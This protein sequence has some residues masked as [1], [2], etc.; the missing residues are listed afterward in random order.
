MRTTGCSCAVLSGICFVLA[1]SAC[2]RAH[3]D[4]VFL[5]YGFNGYLATDD[6][7]MDQDNP[8]TNYGSELLLGVYGEVND[9][10]EIDESILIRFDLTGVLPPQVV[11]D[12]AR[13]GFRLE[14]KRRLTG[15]D[16]EVS[17]GA[18]R[19]LN[20]PWIEDEATWYVFNQSAYWSEPGCEWEGLDRS[21]IEDDIVDFYPNSVVGVMHYWDVTDSVIEWCEEGQPNNGW[22]LRVETCEDQKR[23]VWLNS[24]EDPIA[25]KRPVL[26]VWYTPYY[27]LTLNVINGPWGTV[28]VDPDEPNYEAGTPVVLTAEPNP[29]KGFKHWEIYDPNHPGDPNYRVTDGN[30]VI[31]IVMNADREVTAVFKCGAGTGPMLLPMVLGLV[32]LSVAARRW[33][34][35]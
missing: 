2:S 8:T 27:T 3:A 35:R 32:V 31:T 9:V 26:E 20:R 6:T 12:E 23:G 10:E 16:D 5:R 19:V 13:L 22:L 17:I 14:D 30:S 24:K 28:D 4:H 7:Y 33:S 34:R 21:D 15:E 25:G 1:V 11:I 29:D 18:Y